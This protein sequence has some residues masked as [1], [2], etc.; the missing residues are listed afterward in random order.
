MRNIRTY[1]LYSCLYYKLG[2]TLGSCYFS[3]SEQDYFIYFSIFSSTIYSKMVFGLF[4]QIK[5]YGMRSKFCLMSSSSSTATEFG[6]F[7]MKN[8]SFCSFCME[9]CWFL[10]ASCNSLGLASPLFLG[11]VTIRYA[12]FSSNPSTK[13]SIDLYPL[14][15]LRGSN[16]LQFQ[17]KNYCTM[18]RQLIFDKSFA[19]QYFFQQV[20]RTMVSRVQLGDGVRWLLLM[21]LLVSIPQAIYYSLYFDTSL[22]LILLFVDLQ[23]E[24]TSGSGQNLP[25]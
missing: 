23:Y 10:S 5:P 2:S 1:L 6:S 21:L 22:V 9:S 16:N 17:L 13:N 18:L 4:L 14:I 24:I 15:G 20:A 11:K 8:E 7:T 19:K 3:F 12:F 25:D